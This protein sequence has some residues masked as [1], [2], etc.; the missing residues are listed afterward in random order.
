MSFQQIPAFCHQPKVYPHKELSLMAVANS[1]SRSLPNMSETCLVL[2]H[3]PT[4]TRLARQPIMMEGSFNL[5]GIPI[6]QIAVYRLPQCSRNPLTRQWHS[7]FTFRH[8][9]LS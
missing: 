6:F 7:R 2:A 8:L 3:T 5:V 9:I 4:P 1:S